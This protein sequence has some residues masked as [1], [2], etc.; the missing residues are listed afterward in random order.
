MTTTGTIVRPDESVP[1]GW[2][3]GKWTIDPPWPH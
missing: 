3:A 1:A 2:V